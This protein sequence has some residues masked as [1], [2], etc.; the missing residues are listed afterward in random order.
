MVAPVRFKPPD[1]NDLAKPAREITSRH[2][3]DRRSLSPG[4]VMP[5]RGIPLATSAETSQRVAALERIEVARV[6]APA[7]LTMTPLLGAFVARHVADRMT[8]R[9]KCGQ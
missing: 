9:G 4:R 5:Q 2:G 6:T 8:G 1:Q 7:S 3:V